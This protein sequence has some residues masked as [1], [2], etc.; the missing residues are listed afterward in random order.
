MTIKFNPEAKT[1]DV[2]HYKRNPI[3]RVPVRAARIGIETKAE[4]KRV[5]TE[6]VIQVERELLCVL[7]GAHSR[8]L[9][10]P[11]REH[12]HHRRNSGTDQS[13]SG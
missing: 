8:S 5:F 7:K 2:S 3:T 12:N 10:K 1:Y 6:L 11:L 4:A 13:T 9:G